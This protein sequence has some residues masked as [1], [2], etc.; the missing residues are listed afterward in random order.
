MT[1]RRQGTLLCR[2]NLLIRHVWVKTLYI[3]GNL[4]FSKLS[5]RAMCPLLT[6]NPQSSAATENDTEKL[7]QCSHTEGCQPQCK[8]VGGL[9][10]WLKGTSGNEGGASAALS[11]FP[12]HSITVCIL[13]NL[14][15]PIVSESRISLSMS[16]L[17]TSVMESMEGCWTSG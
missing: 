2:D 11:L 1:F 17:F 13:C 9:I 12:P 5:L 16:S 6:G 10:A 3:F 14:V 15:S 4:L 8:V 7:P